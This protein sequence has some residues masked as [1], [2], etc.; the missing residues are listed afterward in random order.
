MSR[1]GGVW[2]L[3]EKEENGSLG[4]GWMG[5]CSGG[6]LEL[7]HFDGRAVDGLLR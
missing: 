7:G 3:G 1:E 4:I 5:V 6:E 2:Q